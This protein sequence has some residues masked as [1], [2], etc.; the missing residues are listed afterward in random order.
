MSHQLYCPRCLTTFADNGDRCPNL[1]CG[2]APPDS[3]WGRILQPGEALDRNYKIS[4]VLAVGGAGLTYLARELDESGTPIAPDLAIKV[5]YS[6]RARGSY[7][8]RLATEAQIL[9][10][11]AH[12]HIVQCRGFVHRT[13]RDPY[14]VTLFE[15]GGSLTEHLRRCGPLRPSVAA[16]VARQVLLALDTAHQKGVVHRDLKPDNVLL[17]DQVPAE[18]VP[19]IRVADFGIAKVSGGISSQATKHGH[20]VGT[21]EFAAPEQF[22]HQAPTAAT[23]IFATGA[24]LYYTLT[25]QP[26]VELSRRNDIEVSL[27]EMLEQVPP[28]LKATPSLDDATRSL[29]QN[30]LTHTMAVE[31]ERRWT[32]HQTIAALAAITGPKTDRVTLDITSGGSPERVAT[33]APTGLQVQDSPAPDEPEGV[34]AGVAASE[35]VPNE[36]PPQI[37]PASSPSSTAPGQN[38]GTSPANEPPSSA[39]VL[40]GIGSVLMVLVMLVGVL[41]VLGVVGSAV[42]IFQKTAPTA[43][44]ETSD[45]AMQTLGGEDRVAL[46]AALQAQL[47]RSG[48]DCG[49]G[50]AVFEATTDAEGVPTLLQ[51]EGWNA[52]ACVGETLSNLALPEHANQQARVA[53]HW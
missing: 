53:L 15:E 47:D 22:E 1:G 19:H 13:G 7:L 35:P 29:L 26:P 48:R 12:P 23:D 10:E 49:Q 42:L 6:A 40:G 41:A 44:D 2:S 32:A 21:P 34:H 11:L 27:D 36:E 5:L 33:P 24:L 45:A 8:R 39:R 17:A 31:P 43:G 37:E 20:F 4:R 9:Q 51:A 50:H 14:L 52:P 46:Q 16:S 3:G 38:S 18:E 30:V 28:Q 25:G